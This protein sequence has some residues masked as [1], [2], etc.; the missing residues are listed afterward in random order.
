MM[1]RANP[2]EVS[3]IMPVYNVGKYVN[4]CLKSVYQQTYSMP[5]ELS[6]F[7]DG[8][9]DDSLD[10]VQQ[11]KPLLDKRD[12]STVIS[13]HGE[14]PRGVGYA[15]NK[16]VQQSSGKYLCFLDADD[17][18]HKSRI[19]SQLSLAKTLE[20]N[21]VI[22]TKFHR[23]PEGST[24]RYTL[25]ANTTT[26][27]QL[28]TQRY[29]S[30]GPTVIMPTWFC[31]RSVFDV[32]SFDET[33]NG[34]PEDLLFFNKH[35]DLGGR[36]ARVDEDLLMYRYRPG[37]ITFSVSEQT[38][39]DIRVEA[40]EKNVLASWPRF[41]IWNA[42]KQGRKLYRSLSEQ[43]QRKVIAFC[44][45]DEKK[46]AQGFYTHQ[47]SEFRPKPQVPIVHYSQVEKPI[48]ICIKLGLTHG[49]F[50]EYL[51]TCDLVEGKDYYHFN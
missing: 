42:G 48:I 23:L 26:Q 38:I 8:S 51:E 33:S 15:K 43:N 30:H 11:W 12:I 50:E 40:L 31:H 18:M 9:T 4:E 32:Q 49:Q 37:S 17:V 36:L 45:V 47:E 28:Y 1:I 19:Q 41:S 46:I 7:N 2:L 14:A 10:I 16:A 20:S 3:V 25:W 44:D 13:G 34:I 27:D 6:I 21:T 24:K 5:F 39:W 22:G 35:L 29:T